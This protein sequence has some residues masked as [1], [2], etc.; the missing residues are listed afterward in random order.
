MGRDLE[1]KDN[2]Q[3]DRRPGQ[4]GH[5]R[6][7]EEVGHI[8]GIAGKA[9]NAAGAGAFARGG[10]KGGDGGGAED[11]TGETAGEPG[12]EARYKNIAAFES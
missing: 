8:H 7:V 2:S 12:A 11:Q 1:Y 6:E 3:Q 9:V 10:G 5:P 4:K